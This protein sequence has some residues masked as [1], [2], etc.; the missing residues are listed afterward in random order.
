V[1]AAW[2]Q[3]DAVKSLISGGS[4]HLLKNQYNET[5]RD[6]ASRYGKQE[7]VVYLDRSGITFEGSEYFLLRIIRL[8]VMLL[9]K[10]KIPYT[11]M[12]DILRENNVHNLLHI[13]DQL[14]M[15]TPLSCLA[16]LW[17]FN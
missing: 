4:D 15:K 7:C 11:I 5:A 14:I 13:N 2:G 16:Q 17:N 6:M 3:L 1:A 10:L 12:N 8:A 9:F